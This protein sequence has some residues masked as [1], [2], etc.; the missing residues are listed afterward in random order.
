MITKTKKV[1][2]LAIFFSIGLVFYLRSNTGLGGALGQERILASGTYTSTLGGY[3]ITDTDKVETACGTTDVRNALSDAATKTKQEDLDKSFWSY[4]RS[5]IKEYLIDSK[6]EQITNYAK[7]NVVVFV[8]P[9]IFAVISIL[10]CF[11]QFIW[12]LTFSYC[13]PDDPNKGCCRGKCCQ[14]TACWS[15][16]ILPLLVFAVTIGWIIT[17]GDMIDSLDHTKCGVTSKKLFRFV[18]KNRYNKRY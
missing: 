10:C 18:L 15:T 8:G 3:A 9:A 2:L 4:G 13:R 12:I 16:M 17:M 1:T 7:E 11:F 5:Y 6:M 14:K